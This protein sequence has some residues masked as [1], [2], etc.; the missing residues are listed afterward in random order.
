MDAA[1]MTFIDNFI[2]VVSKSPVHENVATFLHTTDF[3]SSP[4]ILLYGSRGFPH[5]VF[6]TTILKRKFNIHAKN[7]ECVWNKE[8]LYS[9]NPCYFQIDFANPCQC[10]NVATIA[11]FVKDV[12]SHGS[13]HGSKHVFVM[14]NIEKGLTKENVYQFRVLLE[15]YSNNAMFITTT[16]HKSKIEPPLLSRLLHFRIPLLDAATVRDV[17]RDVLSLDLPEDYEQRDIHRAILTGVVFK[18]K[19][20]LL[21]VVTKYH[22]P[23]LASMS[24]PTADDLRALAQKIYINDVSLSMLTED[25]L[26]SCT[27]PEK[28]VAEAAYIDTLA[29]KSDGHRMSLFIELLLNISFELKEKTKTKK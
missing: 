21:D 4:N 9:E 1:W 3:T 18:H 20:D 8:V 24:K 25:L 6:I 15:R 28:L 7:R 16:Y 26:H 23:S 14:S 22:V 10:K 12:V 5:D 2:T 27:N 17:C 13:I 11:A 29:A 19:P